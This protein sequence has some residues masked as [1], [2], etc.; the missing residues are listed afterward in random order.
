[1]VSLIFL[2]LFE[3]IIILIWL[4]RWWDY[5]TI[6]ELIC[7]VFEIFVSPFE[8]HIMQNKQV[9]FLSL[10][11]W[12]ELGL[13]L[14]ILLISRY[15]SRDWQ[16]STFLAVFAIHLRLSDLFYFYWH[17]FPESC[18]AQVVRDV[19]LVLLMSFLIFS[20]FQSTCKLHLWSTLHDLTDCLYSLF[21]IYFDKKF[22]WQSASLSHATPWSFVCRTSR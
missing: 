16:S 20:V 10:S 7:S 13:S 15:D 18:I 22:L 4:R 9:P 11:G 17:I 1:M 2:I 12:S 6:M 3:I 21:W 8:F 19:L 5:E 14:I